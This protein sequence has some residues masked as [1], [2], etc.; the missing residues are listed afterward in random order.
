MD[1]F[2]VLFSKEQYSIPQVE[3]CR[4]LLGVL[5]GLTKSHYKR[6][7]PYASI[8]DNLYD[9]EDSFQCN[10][11]SS[12]PYLPVRLFKRAGLH[13]LKSEDIFKTLTSSGTTS[14]QPSLIYLDKETSVLQT[15]ALAA[16]ITSFIGK[17]RLPMIL[18][19]SS[20]MLKNRQMF[21]ARGAGLMGMSYFGRDHFYALDEN[22]QIDRNGL[23]QFLEKHGNDTILL[24]GFTFMVWQY[25]YQAIKKMNENIKFK[26]AILI[27]GGGWKTL[28]DQSISNDDFKNALSAQLGI[29]RIYNYYGMV[30]QVGGVYMECEEG[31]FHTPNFSEI[32]IRD[33]KNWET[34]P[35]GQSGVIQTLS[36]LPRSYPGHSLLT[37]DLGTIYGIDNCNCG[38]KGTY[39][40]IEGRIPSAELRGCS[41]THAQSH[42]VT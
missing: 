1:Q 31:F 26:D 15:K 16:I 30:E 40:S 21:S 20:A 37:E 6:C 32:L 7:A 10:N 5:N 14:Q 17:K 18:I 13:S 23:V 35:V 33:Y 12:I 8:I 11:L 19:D 3:K 39:F 25:F 27:H 34:L 4:L 2:E 24:F 28:S 41:D 42:P 36:V 22:M 38:R 9:S 29:H